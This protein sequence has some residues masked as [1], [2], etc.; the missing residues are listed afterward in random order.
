MKTHITE[1]LGAGADAMTN[2]YEVVFTMPTGTALSVDATQT[3]KLRIRADAFNP[4]AD[5]QQTYEV[6]WKTVALTRPAS[7]IIMDRVFTITFR[8]DANYDLYRTLLKWKGLTSAGSVGYA[9][10][11]MSILGSVTVSALAS[12][13]THPKMV[14]GKTSDAPGIKG[15]ASASGGSVILW[16]YN[17]VWIETITNP[18]FST[19]SADPAK[20]TATFRFGSFEDEASTFANSLL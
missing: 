7:K 9:S 6:H 11:E 14:A 17:D 10:Q 2:M 18:E 5:S 15:A 20:V 4:P 12:A 8:V 19:E 3:A 1:L 13:I 16:K